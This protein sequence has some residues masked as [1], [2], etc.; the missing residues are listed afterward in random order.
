[1]FF[2][3]VFI[4][5]LVILSGKYRISNKPLYREFYLLCFLFVFV[6]TSLRFD[7]G[8]DYKSYWEMVSNLQI[9]QEE[10]HYL[11]PTM[12]MFIHL[13]RIFSYPPLIFFIYALITN[14]LFFYLIWKY[15]GNPMLGLLVYCAFFYLPTLGF[16]R[17]GAALAI[18][19]SSYP[20]IIGRKPIKFILICLLAFLF[21]YPSLVAI[22]I[23]PLY[24]WISWRKLTTLILATAALFPLVI[25]TIQ[26]LF[27]QLSYLHYL[28][29]LNE[30]SG[31]N[32]VRMVF[33][34]LIL[35]IYFIA[36]KKNLTNEL[37]LI[38]V[39]SVGVITSFVLG[40]HIGGRI[41]WYF[42]VFLC[43]SVPKVL[44]HYPSFFRSI[45]SCMLCG[46]FLSTLYVST[47]SKD[48]LQY[49]PYKTIF[50][51][52]IDAPRFK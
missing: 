49:T 6:I 46:I 45:A 37:S 3:F 12:Q 33:L 27:P 25:S 7:I 19:L 2:W 40:G 44:N 22:I 36:L 4:C 17:Q 21:H 10:F 50:E 38:L 48:K 41:G 39:S 20:Y 24:N 35:V 15:S 13:S 43:I 28:E 14:G 18:I 5:F 23:Y 42:L 32:M 30:L 8:F 34:G 29:R 51:I 1:M 47:L 26:A 16:I 31:G 11:E 52:N 9:R